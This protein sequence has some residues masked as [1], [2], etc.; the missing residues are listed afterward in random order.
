MFGERSTDS[1]GF[2]IGRRT[3]IVIWGVDEC[4]QS[5]SKVPSETRQFDSEAGRR[6]EARNECKTGARGPD[7]VSVSQRQST[8]ESAAVSQPPSTITVIYSA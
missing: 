5:K 1:L 2:V 4:C 6:S 8:A 3:E 7:V